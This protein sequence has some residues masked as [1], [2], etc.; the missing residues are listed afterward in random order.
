MRPSIAKRF[1]PREAHPLATDNESHN[2][3]GSKDDCCKNYPYL[4]LLTLGRLRSEH[5][6][7]VYLLS[8]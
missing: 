5:Y 3:N 7:K 6:A 2:Q 1:F 4:Y 8:T